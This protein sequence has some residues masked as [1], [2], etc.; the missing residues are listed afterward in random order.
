MRLDIIRHGGLCPGHPRLGCLKE[1]KTWM[2]ATSAGMTLR[3]FRRSTL[4]RARAF[5][6]KAEVARGDALIGCDVFRRSVQ[7]EFAELHDIGAVGDLQRG[8]RLLFDQ[9]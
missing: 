6:L 7:D 2:P 9:H 3:I 5:V 8:L 4:N 1:S